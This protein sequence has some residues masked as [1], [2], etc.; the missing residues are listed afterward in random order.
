MSPNR[1]LLWCGVAAGPLFL[2]VSTLAGALRPEY[3]LARHPVS[4][5]SLTGSGGVQ[6]ANFLVAGALLTAFAV[7]AHRE[8]GRG[9]GPGPLPWL[10]GL[11]GAGLIGAGLFRADPVSG[12]PPGTPHELVYTPLGA[13]HD[14]ASLLF[15]FGLPL[16]FT[17]FALRCLARRAWVPAGYSVLTLVVFFACFLWAGAGFQQNPELVAVG[18]LYQRAALLAGFAWTTVLALLLLRSEKTA[19]AATV[20]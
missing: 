16:A 17:V 2:A 7:G 3:S 18:G 9:G 5:L 15:F 14:A 1:G 19:G 20:R 13:L 8:L 4:S 10:L 6:V 11:A 12:Y